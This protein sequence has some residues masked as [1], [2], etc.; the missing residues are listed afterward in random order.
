[1]VIVTGGFDDI[2]ARDVRFLEEASKFGP[3]TVRLLQDTALRSVK[4]PFE[5]RAYILRSLR[6]VA[7]VEVDTGP[8]EPAAV[9]VAREADV[10]AA[11]PDAGGRTGQE[12]R[13]IPEQVLDNFSLPVPV[14]VPAPGRDGRTV[15]VSGC[16]DWLHSGHIRFFEAAALGDLHV[17]LGS[18]ATIR[19]LKGPGHPQFGEE[20]RR[21]LVSAVRYVRAAHVS[22]GS[23]WLDF[24]D[25]VRTL[26]PGIF[27]VNEDGDKPAKRAFCSE[28]GI[29]YR[30]LKRAPAV[31]LPARSSTSLRGY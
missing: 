19:E 16:F 26:R 3:V 31:G 11:M 4:F 7:A 28:L 12:I 14:P 27:V 21:Y 30:V 1:M 13:I 6:F 22:R 15:A 2:R 17:F 5:E 8:L 23:G 24:A 29:D 18:D 20:E 9:F 25:D 10:L